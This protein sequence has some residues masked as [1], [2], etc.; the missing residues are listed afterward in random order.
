MALSARKVETAAAGRH[1]DGRGLMLLVKPT[2]AR[3]WVLR[4]QIA[5]CRRD[6][7]LGSWPEISLSMA[8]ERA[9]D[10]RR[11]IALRR[12]PLNEKSK[13]KKLLF[14]DAATALIAAKQNGWRNAKHAAQWTAT[15][16]RY[17]YPILGQHDVRAITTDIVLSVLSP[18][19]TEKPETASRVRQRVEA[20]LDYATAIG[21]R[22]EANP[23]RWR[24]HLDRLLAQPSKVRSVAHHAALH[25]RQMPELMIELAAR[26]GFG[27]KALIFTILTASRSGEVR[28]ATWSEIDLDRRV[29]T[30]P[31]TR[32]KAGKEHRVPLS[33]A[34][35]AQLG[36]AGASRDLLFPGGR[37]LRTPMSDMTLAAVLKRLGRQDITVHGFRSS[38]RDWAGE[39]TNFPRE[40]IE[41]ALAHRLKDK[42]EAA[43][44]RGDLLQ[45]RRH[46]M[47]A[48]A[49]YL[50]QAAGR[51]CRVASRS[52]QSGGHRPDKALS[53]NECWLPSFVQDRHQATCPR[54]RN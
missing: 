21:A 13:V 5:G 18:I 27:V 9:L 6:M 52:G 11:M 24:G 37:G 19:W 29:W 10:A 28:G 14:R 45:K 16:Q 50:T 32:M 4:Y 40:V 34:A 46:L 38:F 2:G 43:Y 54:S 7:G 30:V 42:A 17:A 20:V 49:I 3:S 53:S 31:A 33:D 15:L 36:E 26:D 22:D 23:A 35:I 47:D 39:T 44:A 51:G 8:R 1:S 41:A 48:W 12:D 25:W